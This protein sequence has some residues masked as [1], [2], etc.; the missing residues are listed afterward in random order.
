MVKTNKY[1]VMIE[2]HAEMIEKPPFNMKLAAKELRAWVNESREQLQ[3][4]DIRHAAMFPA[5]PVLHHSAPLPLR[6]NRD[7]D[8]PAQLPLPLESTMNTVTLGKSREPAFGSKRQSKAAA[9]RKARDDAAATLA[10]EEADFKTGMVKFRTD[11]Q[12]L[13]FDDAN[14]IANDAWKRRQAKKPKAKA[15]PKVDEEADD[16]DAEPAPI[17]VDN[18]RREP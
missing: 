17:E 13:A 12:E 18:E 2:R 15:K 6:R 14:K 7:E 3:P 11:E 1:K 9:K 5:M 4:L 10:Q 8:A 16:T